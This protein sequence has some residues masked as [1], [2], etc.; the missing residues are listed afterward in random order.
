V[1]DFIRKMIGTDR[2]SEVR[3]ATDTANSLGPQIAEQA[4]QLTNW[5]NKLAEARQRQEYFKGI[6]ATG[7]SD[8]A[9]QA[10]MDAALA[11]QHIAELQ[12][13]ITEGS[14]K[15]LSAF[16]ISTGKL[17]EVSQ[18]FGSGAAETLMGIA[19]SFGTAA[20]AAMRQA[21]GTIG[22]NVNAPTAAPN[23]GTNTNLQTG[24]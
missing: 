20:G 10:D 15:I 11:Q 8:A 6:G 19:S 18:S 13:S 2:T 7:M 12:A 22:V 16:D 3:G 9:Q 1:D 23:T 24:G 14:D 5:L 21:I 17:V 4:S